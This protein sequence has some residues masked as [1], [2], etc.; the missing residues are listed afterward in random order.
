[1]KTVHAGCYT[2]KRETWRSGE[3]QVMNEALYK[4][5]GKDVFSKIGL[6][7]L[8]VECKKKSDIICLSC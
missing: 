5:D 1:M 3:Q 4:T 8:F 2:L 6:C 7:G